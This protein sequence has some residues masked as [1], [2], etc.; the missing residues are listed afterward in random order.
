MNM[1]NKTNKS[2]V[3]MML[4]FLMVIV[5]PT[6]T[7]CDDD[8][9]EGGTPS[10]RYFRIPDASKADSMIVGAPWGT[11]VAII[12]ENLNSVKTIKFNDIE[13]SLNSCYVTD[14]AILVSVPNGFPTVETN[15]VYLYPKN[16]GD[17]IV[18]D[19]VSMVPAPAIS[20][21]SSLVLSE[22]MTLTLTG[23]YMTSDLKISLSG[24][25]VEATEVAKDFTT[26]KFILPS[27]VETAETLIAITK[28]GNTTYSQK[29]NDIHGNN[30][31]IDF[32]N[33]PYQ[34]WMGD[35]V[36]TNENKPLSGNYLHINILGWSQWGWANPFASDLTAP[37]EW[38][39]DV[40]KSALAFEIRTNK[41]WSTSGQLSYEFV[42]NIGSTHWEGDFSYWYPWEKAT[43]DTQ[44]EWQTV[45]LPLTNPIGSKS[46]SQVT[47]TFNKWTDADVN[48]NIA[49]MLWGDY[50]ELNGA[51]A[52]SDIDIDI[53]NVRIISLSE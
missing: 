10:I 8:D 37:I 19:F 29:L 49:F 18:A 42:D 35:A 40:S 6:F 22:G 7:A 5:A 13:A 48:K 9:D 44:G 17:S 31:F 3:A 32:D 11:V 26:A 14:N 45:I 20:N 36:V 39:G 21:I 24:T 51:G 47:P 4:L 52:T 50:L 43:F 38:N 16:G 27:G 1:I 46:Q 12:G 25:I 33:L 2:L 30:I 41:P 15:K 53:D 34:S 28:Y 23:N